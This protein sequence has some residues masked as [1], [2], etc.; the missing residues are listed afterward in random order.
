MHGRGYVEPTATPGGSVDGRVTLRPG[1]HK[2]I[3]NLTSADDRYA[4]KVNLG[5][6][7]GS[8][9]WQGD[10]LMIEYGPHCSCLLSPGLHDVLDNA[11]SALTDHQSS[12]YHVM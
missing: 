10:G 4:S 5:V 7:V 3:V 1:R 6:W 12:V 11:V 9:V 8:W 2:L